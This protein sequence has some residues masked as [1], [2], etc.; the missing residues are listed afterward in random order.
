MLYRPAPAFYTGPVMWGRGRQRQGG[1]RAS[2]WLVSAGVSVVVSFVLAGAAVAAPPS[3]PTF[4]EP[5]TDGEVVNP[6]DV[7]MEVDGF[8]DADGH[9]HFCTDWQIQ[10][11]LGEVV[12]DAPCVTGL[13]SVHVHLGD[14]TFVNS[15]PGAQLDFETDY[16]LRVRFHD[17]AGEIGAWS[18]RPFR[19]S[20]E[21]PPGV[22]A[23][24]PWAARQPGYVVEIVASGFQ[25]R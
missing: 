25:L 15:P 6:S 9:T 7:H 19:T 20:P 16:M 23:P 2:P 13:E 8:S 18:E 21:G 3:M 24:I 12:W 10:T 11:P 22:P 14:G 1:R 17:S 5:T 4:L